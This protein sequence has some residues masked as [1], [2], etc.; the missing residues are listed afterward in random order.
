MAVCQDLEILIREYIAQVIHLSPAT[1]TD[2]RPRVFKPHYAYDDSLNLHFISDIERQHSK[3]I[4]TNPSV[5]SSVATQHFLNQNVRGIYFGGS[6]QQPEDLVK[7]Q[8]A[9]TRRFHDSPQ[10]AQTAKAEGSARFI[11]FR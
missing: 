7:M 5:D 6:A 10:L 11:R 1:A 8:Q 3:D 2:N 4:H 9:Y